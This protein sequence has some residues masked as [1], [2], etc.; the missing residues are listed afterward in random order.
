[1]DETVCV[2][3][4]EPSNENCATSSMTGGGDPGPMRRSP[5]DDIGTP[6][7]TVDEPTAVTTVAWDGD[8]DTSR[9]RPR[10][11]RR[12]P[13]P[14]STQQWRLM[15]RVSRVSRVPTPARR[16]QSPLQQPQV[17]VWSCASDESELVH[18]ALSSFGGGRPVIKD[19]AGSP[20]RSD[21]QQGWT[22]AR[23]ASRLSY[24]CPVDREVGVRVEARAGEPHVVD[25]RQRDRALI[26]AHDPPA[27]AG[28]ADP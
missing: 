22:W 7:G 27:H 3:V 28:P 12:P 15:V 13:T 21:A 25:V 4:P 2:C 23:F 17:V 6:T 20:W 24:R 26:A 19:D 11:R 14:P 10:P 16:V 5:A 8:P 18:V 9:P 1:M